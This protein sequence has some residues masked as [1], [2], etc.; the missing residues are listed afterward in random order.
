MHG[1]LDIATSS[2]RRMCHWAIGSRT[3]KG[4]FDSVSEGGTV[5][6][7]IHCASKKMGGCVSL[8]GGAELMKCGRVSASSTLLE[9]YLQSSSLLSLVP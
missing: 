2:A 5:L 3:E 8:K 4:F 7:F 1:K 6:P 9:V